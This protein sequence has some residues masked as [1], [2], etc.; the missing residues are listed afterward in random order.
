M[1][2]LEQCFTAM[3]RDSDGLD[4]LTMGC[5]DDNQR[6]QLNC[7]VG[8]QPLVSI[9]C[10]NNASFCNRHLMP[11]YV[12]DDSAYRNHFDTRDDGANTASGNQSIGLEFLE[13]PKYLKHCQV[14][15]RQC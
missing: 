12:T 8:S 6:A 5:I 9:R 10:C 11:T 3:V 4:V 13:W 14:H 15:Y 2:W 7:H 1:M